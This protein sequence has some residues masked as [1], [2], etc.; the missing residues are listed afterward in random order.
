MQPINDPRTIIQS[1]MPLL[2]DCNQTNV[3]G[4]IIDFR[5]NLP[6]TP[7]CCH[8]MNSIDAGQFVCQDPGG[9]NEIPMTKYM[10]ANTQ[11]IFFELV[12]SNPEFV[13]AFR[14]SVLA[15]LKGPWYRK[16]YNWLQIFGQ[17]VGFPWISFPG[18]DDCSQDTIFHLKAAASKL[19]QN[20]M[21]VIM[22]IPNNS[23]PEEFLAIKL[24]NPDV[25]NAKYSYDSQTGVVVKGA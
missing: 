1:E 6:N 15:K 19:P 5:T 22:G 18:L 13:A 7:P 8:S 4:E 16:T 24:D 23:N 10:V 12:E 2:I 17:A 11:L 21:E 14:A 3:T 9:Y 20:S 25:F